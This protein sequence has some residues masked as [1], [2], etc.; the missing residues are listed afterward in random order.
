[1]QGPIVLIL[2]DADQCLVPRAADNI[3]SISSLLNLSDGILGSLLDIRIIATTNAKQEKMDQAILRD[4][5]LSKRIEVNALEYDQANHIFQRLTQSKN[6]LPMKDQRSEMY[7]KQNSKYT[8]A[9]IYK[10]ARSHGWQP[11]TTTK[12]KRTNSRYAAEYP[13]VVTY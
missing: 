4:G 13:E 8:L 1:M 7:P 10:L 9:E 5:R 3:S 2:E 6:A 11:S 12:S